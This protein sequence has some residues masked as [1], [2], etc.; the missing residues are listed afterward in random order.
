[1]NLLKKHYEK[2]ILAALLLIFILLLVFQIIVILQAKDIEI[3][4]VLGI[5]PPKPG[6]PRQ[7]DFS[8]PELTHKMIFNS[9]R[10]VWV[11]NPAKAESNDLC[12]AEALTRCPHGPH[13]IPPSDYPKMRAKKPGVCSFCGEK[14][15]VLIP[16]GNISE[17]DSD[18]DGIPDKVEKRW[19]LDPKNPADAEQDLDNDGFSNIEEFKASTDL[20][21]PKSRPNYAKKLFYETVE[22]EPLGMWITQISYPNDKADVKDWRVSI[23]YYRELDKRNPRRK[24]QY[25]D[26]K[27]GDTF[28]IGEKTYII[29][30]IAKELKYNAKMYRTDN[31]SRVFIHEYDPKTKEKLGLPIS[32]QIA[33]VKGKTVNGEIVNPRQRVTFYFEIDNNTFVQYV[34]DKFTLGDE[35]RGEDVLELEDVVNNV[36]RVKTAPGERIEIKRTEH[37]EPGIPENMFENGPEMMPRRNG[38][39]RPMQRPMP[40]RTGLPSFGN[41]R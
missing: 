28:K 31:L 10:A 23:A 19:G 2:F 34:G 16:P 17:E 29:D 30:R 12:Q 27:I 25:N 5:K 21:N 13:L 36:V 3:G 22:R 32:G 41:N 14:I 7:L 33:T 20:K 40:P 6:Y 37:K 15:K 24:K 4:A 1:M 38:P 9:E 8:K 35:R 39:Q 18:G 26:L 11:G